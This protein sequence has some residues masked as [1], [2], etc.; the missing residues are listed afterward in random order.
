MRGMM[1]GLRRIKTEAELSHI[2]AA[3][4]IAERAFD[5][6]LDDIRRA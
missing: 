2:V 5:E 6:I 3:Q 4:C 1:D